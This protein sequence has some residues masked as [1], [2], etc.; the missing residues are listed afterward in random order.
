MRVCII[1]RIRE[2][3]SQGLCISHI[4]NEVGINRR[5]ARRLATEHGIAV[6]HAKPPAIKPRQWTADEDAVLAAR[7]PH[8]STVAVAAALART[9]NSVYRRANMLG[10][11]KTE[12][13]HAAR[14]VVAEGS[15]YRRMGNW[16]MQR[17]VLEKRIGPERWVSAPLAVWT[18]HHG[19]VPAGMVAAFKEGRSSVDPGAIGIDDIELVTR[20]ELMRRNSYWTNFP[21]EVARVFQLRGA[22]AR[23]IGNRIKKLEETA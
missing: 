2:L 13:Y 12:A 22:L 17:G 5:T 14:G 1:E 4:A 11:S 15:T 7:Y 16:R 19:E 23:K 20:A 3:A 21:P 6:V 10:L 18:E 9:V 8:E